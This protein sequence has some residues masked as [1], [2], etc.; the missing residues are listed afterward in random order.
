[1]NMDKR[2]G[3]KCEVVSMRTALIEKEIEQKRRHLLD[4]YEYNDRIAVNEAVI[5]ASQELD[6]LIIEYL[7]A[8]EAERDLLS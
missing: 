4:V 3:R 7:M 1:M 6:Q 2:T 5:A 8:K